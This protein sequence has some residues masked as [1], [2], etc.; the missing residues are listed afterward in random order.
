MIVSK[1][2]QTLAMEV[3]SKSWENMVVEGSL[4]GGGQAN[5]PEGVDQQQVCRMIGWH[6]LYA[7]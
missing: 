1:A 2:R 6:Y 5:L 4:E 7:E 3:L